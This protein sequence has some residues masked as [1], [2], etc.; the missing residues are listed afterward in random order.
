[1]K[2]ISILLLGVLLVLGA[3]SCKKTDLDRMGTFG[4]GLYQPDF[5]IS[6]IQQ[7]SAASEIWSW[8]T[9]K[10]SSISLPTDGSMYDFTYNGDRVGMVTLT[11]PDGGTQ[12]ANYTYDGTLLTRMELVNG[13][14]TDIVMQVNHDANNHIATLN[15][16]LSDQF[17]FN[18]AISLLGSSMKSAAKYSI[19]N[20]QFAGTL[21]WSGD[22]VEKFLLTGNVTATTTLSDLAEFIELPSVIQGMLEQIGDVEYPLT[23]TLNQSTTYTYDECNNPFYCHYRT[24]LDPSILS[25]NNLLSATTTGTL[26]IKVTVTDLPFI[27]SYPVSRTI[28]LGESHTYSYTYNKKNLPETYTVDGIQYTINY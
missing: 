15:L 2:H 5:H 6:S 22:N 24:N 3:T 19:T 7:G 10:L 9:S 26:E 25:K 11:R 18:T 13:N 21:T 1:M 4:E 14:R 28:D 27:G 20:K 16:D 23:A 17:L 12:R 8:G